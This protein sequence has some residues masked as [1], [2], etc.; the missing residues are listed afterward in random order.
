MQGSWGLLGIRGFLPS[1]YLYNSP[2]R[3][4]RAEADATQYSVL[5]LT[6]LMIWSCR[7]A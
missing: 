6:L 7:F 1:D 2:L 4:A 3:M 5:D